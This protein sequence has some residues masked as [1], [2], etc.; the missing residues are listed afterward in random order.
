MTAASGRH[1]NVFLVVLTTVSTWSLI[2]GYNA[3]DYGGLARMGFGALVASFVLRQVLDIHGAAGPDA[4][5]PSEFI[6]AIPY[7]GYAPLSTFDPNAPK[8]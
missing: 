7:D 5:R 2:S 1:G 3:G 6:D 8:R 4:D